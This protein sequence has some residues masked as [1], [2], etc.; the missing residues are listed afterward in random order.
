ML[1]KYLLFFI[2]LLPS[3]IFPTEQK[4]KLHVLIMCD[5]LSSNIK[6]ASFVDL[7]NM[8]QATTLI[9]RKLKMKKKTTILKGRKMNAG[10]LSQWMQSLSISSNDI[11]IFYYSGHGFRQETDQAPWPSFVI[12]GIKS[13]RTLVPGEK[14]C[15]ALKEH[16]PRFALVLFDCC[17][18]EVTSKKILPFA[19]SPLITH[20][21]SL[22]G[23]SSLFKSTRGMV[24]IT[25]SSP[26]EF[27]IAIVG[28]KDKGSIFTSQFLM[29]LL[30]KAHNKNAT[31]LQVLK[32]AAYRCSELSD[33][34][35]NP[36]GLIETSP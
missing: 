19:K 36:V 28:G 7:D 16:A 23:L 8:K 13:P 34:M 14:I 24:T 35:Q 9:A 15:Q 33:K 2:L 30:Q 21:T 6:K 18:N 5:T 11:V 26:G 29:A 22:P 1:R 3:C 10:P 31:W 12:P 4:P 20:S 25:A 27:S 32:Q 17:N